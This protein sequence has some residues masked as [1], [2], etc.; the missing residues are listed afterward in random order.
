[1][2]KKPTKLRESKDELLEFIKE[3]SR[4][5]GLNLTILKIELYIPAISILKMQLKNT[6][7]NQE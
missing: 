1:M 7:H 3:F 4:I 5:A 2:K 6:I